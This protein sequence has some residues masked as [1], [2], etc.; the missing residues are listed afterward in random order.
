MG[1]SKQIYKLQKSNFFQ[2]YKELSSEKF[3]VIVKGKHN[4]V[5]LDDNIL[6]SN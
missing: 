5:I 3:I 2:N 6:I 1:I 4:L